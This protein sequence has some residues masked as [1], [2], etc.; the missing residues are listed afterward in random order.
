MNPKKLTL[1]E[2]SSSKNCKK[3]EV[4]TPQKD[5]PKKLIDFTT[6]NFT[7]ESSDANLINDVR[8][9]SGEMIS[10]AI[11]YGNR[12]D[13]SKKIRIYCTWVDNNFYMVVQDE[14]YGFDIDNPKYRGVPIPK[15]SLGISYA[16]QRV[17]I[18]YNFQ[19]SASY[20]C[21]RVD[22]DKPGMIESFFKKIH[23]KLTQ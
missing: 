12:R 9:A 23:Q 1:E 4:G 22:Q 14:G 6:E 8:V 19:D 21:K 5:Y 18:L 17:D 10:N 16:K 13:P 15:G 11:K 7:T 2:I 20:L 3:L